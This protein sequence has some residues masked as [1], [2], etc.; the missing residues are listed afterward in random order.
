VQYK[1]LP[2]IQEVQMPPIIDRQMPPII[3][4]QMPYQ[5]GAGYPS[6]LSS[7]FISFPPVLT[8]GPCPP[9]RYAIPMGADVPNEVLLPPTG[10]VPVLGPN[11]EV[12]Y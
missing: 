10:R 9:A 6:N 11:G 8:P 4:P 12:L 2:A 7:S 3:D 5:H 1:P